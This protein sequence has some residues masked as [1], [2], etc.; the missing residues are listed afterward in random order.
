MVRF[1]VEKGADLNLKAEEEEH[2]SART[3]AVAK[4][5]SWLFAGGKQS[6]R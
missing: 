6:D 1:R 4:G 3:L 2:G 5:K